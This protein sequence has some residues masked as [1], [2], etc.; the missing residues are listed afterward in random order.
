MA[1][2]RP[3]A[4]ASR[5]CSQAAGYRVCREYYVNDAGRQM[6]ILAASTWLRYLERCGERFAFPANGYRGDYLLAIAAE[7]DTRHGGALVRPAAAVFADL[8]PDEPQGGDKDVY[9]DAVIARARALFGAAR[10]PARARRWRSDRSSPTSARIS[11]NS[12]CTFDSWFSE[13]SLSDSGEVDRAIGALEAAGHDLR[14]GRRALVQDH[15]LTATR[16][17]A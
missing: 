7:L 16:R 2:T 10:F 3:T 8:P 17:T 15:G 12:A 5:T 13:R 11:R 14:Q 4:P 1:G 9:I 6:E